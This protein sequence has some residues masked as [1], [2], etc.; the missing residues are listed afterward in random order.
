MF[1]RFFCAPLGSIRE[2]NNREFYESSLQCILWHKFPFTSVFRSHSTH[3]Q[4]E[5]TTHCT[6]P[7]LCAKT[8]SLSVAYE[9][10]QY[11]CSVTLTA[12]FKGN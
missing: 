7:D 3:A 4:E 12:T 1:T 2:Q 5:S 9:E 10:S 8:R 11:L 6:S